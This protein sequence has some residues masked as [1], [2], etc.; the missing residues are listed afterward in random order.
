M[1]G[2]SH[3]TQH[4][5]AALS[6]ASASLSQQARSSSAGAAF[7]RSKRRESLLM[8]T[9]IPVPEAQR[10]ALTVTPGS[11]A[12]LFNE[13]ILGEVVAQVQRS[14]LISSNLAVYRSL[15]RGGSLVLPLLLHL[16]IQPP[17]VLRVLASRT[18]SALPPHLA[19]VGASTFGGVRGRLLLPNLRVSG[20][21]SHPLT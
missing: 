11:T 2:F 10:K 12:G 16:W 18:A 9:S 5:N 6:F 21:R 7:V 1:T 20:S 19:L 8:H 17:R 13:D 15:G 14:S 3:P 4:F